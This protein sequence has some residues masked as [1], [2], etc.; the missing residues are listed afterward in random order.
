MIKIAIKKNRLLIILT[1]IG[2]LHRLLFALFFNHMFDF[3]SILALIKSVTDTG[4]ITAGFI[5]L[6]NNNI[7]SQ[8]FG[9]IFYQ[10]GGVWLYFLQFLHVIDIRYIFD[11]KPYQ[12]IESYMVGFNSWNPPLY[13]LIAIK[14]S[15]F[16]YDFTLLFFIYKI[17]KLIDIKKISFVFLFWAI[18]P[19]M[20]FVPY[21]MYQSD[22]AMMAF[23][24]GGVYFTLKALL[25]Q[26][27]N[28]LW[29]KILAILLI[30]V[31]AIIKQVPILIIPFVI[32]I[33]SSSII[34]F[35]GYSSIFLFFYQFFSQPWSKDY[36]LQRTFFL[37][38]KE[39][40]AI[41]NF[42]LNNV[43]VF[44]LLYLIVF[45]IF[46]LNRDKIIKKTFNLLT[47]ITLILCGLYISENPELLFVNF[48]IWIMP[49]IL[50]LVLKDPKYCLL[51]AA[52]IIGFLKRNMIDNTFL[53]GALTESL[54]T[55]FSGTPS[56]L[57]I[58]QYSMSPILIG[59]IINTLMIAIYILYFIILIADLVGR[60]IIKLGIFGS[61]LS[62]NYKKIVIGLLLSFY[63]FFGVDY[64]IK[65]NYTTLK[66]E[67]I[68]MLDERISLKK[69]ILSMEIENPKRQLLTALEL[70]GR[71][72]KVN[73]IDH[74]VLKFSEGQRILLEQSVMDYQLP[75][76]PGEILIFF[77]KGINNKK[78]KLEIFKDRKNNDIEIQKMKKIDQSADINSFNLNH[79][80]R[81]KFTGDPF[82]IKLYQRIAYEDVFSGFD[83]HIK[84]KPKF[85]FVYGLTILVIVLLIV[86]LFRSKPSNL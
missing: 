14:L 43:S 70:S 85:F 75:E 59:L 49:F 4:D 52:P 25:T 47:L 15:Q 82:Y 64:L 84:T 21:A 22:I 61:Y 23:F 69:N 86:K 27:N 66:S 10:M 68:Q 34:S 42:Q 73:N 44:M 78:I 76:T 65:T 6:R 7:L 36:L 31:G 11:V 55:S 28:N 38:S 8:F 41:F 9:K 62:V 29:T 50:L 16:F 81:L 83:K 12:T 19:F 20:I 37:T 32:I 67:P 74:L 53:T 56:Y 24:I 51:L 5:V 35:I 77:K 58:L 71:V 26:T 39:S 40:L 3:G 60:E 45:L 46:I 57:R 79:D 54:G 2:V 30:T 17:A 48:N 72:I 13:Q 18:N 80:V 63:L 1:L 33:F